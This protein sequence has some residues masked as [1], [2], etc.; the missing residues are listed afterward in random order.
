MRSRLIALPIAGV[1]LLGLLFVTAGT[2]P[3]GRVLTS[4]GAP[5]AGLAFLSSPK[6]KG[7]A[8]Y[9]AG[10]F[11]LAAKAFEAADD[12]YNQGLAAAHAGDYAAALNAWDRVLAMNPADSEARANHALV[13]GLLAGTRFDPVAAPD[14]RKGDVASRAPPGQ[15]KARAASTGDGANNKKAGFWMPEITSEGLRRVPKIFDAQFVAANQRWL[16][17]MEDQPG[18][19]LR[20]RLK[21][22][23]KA[24]ITNG[25]ALPDPEDPQ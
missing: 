9:K 1:V 17:T 23:Q 24:R 21:A 16:A 2:E 19:Y 10:A 11:D 15:G 14:E 5:K 8:L 12:N 18:R 22:E 6:A 25:T 4:I 20:E 13:T 7:E 3:L